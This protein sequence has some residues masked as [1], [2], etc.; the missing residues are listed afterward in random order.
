MATNTLGRNRIAQL[1]VVFQFS[2][3]QMAIVIEPGKVV[4]FGIAKAVTTTFFLRR[5]EF[6]F[7]VVSNVIAIEGP[8]Q[9]ATIVSMIKPFTRNGGCS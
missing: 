7:D 1:D 6:E 9:L 4:A 2:P 8:F 3:L 5:V